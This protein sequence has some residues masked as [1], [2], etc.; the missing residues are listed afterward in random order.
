MWAPLRWRAWVSRPHS[1]SATTTLSGTDAVVNVVWSPSD[2]GG[3]PITGYLVRAVPASITGVR[4]EADVADFTCLAGGSD[5]ACA[6]QV[7]VGLQ[8]RFANDLESGARD[9]NG[10]VNPDEINQDNDGQWLPMNLVDTDHLHG[11]FSWRALARPP[12]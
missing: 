9:F 1:V 10:R 11:F 8:Y 2:R 5:T 4:F 3:R 7:P 6:I 12:S